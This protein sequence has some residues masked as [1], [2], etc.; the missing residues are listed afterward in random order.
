MYKSNAEITIDESWVS[1]LAAFDGDIP[2][3][4]E[5][6]TFD[7]DPDDPIAVEWL[8]DQLLL[9]NLSKQYRDKPDVKASPSSVD[10]L[11]TTGR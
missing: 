7:I 1:R 5:K 10:V 8:E 9:L 6:L 11:L 2:R 4:G 3:L